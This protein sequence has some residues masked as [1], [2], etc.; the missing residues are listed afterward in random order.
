MY[1]NVRFPYS[2]FFIVLTYSVYM[3]GY[4]TWHIYVA[5]AFS[6]PVGWGVTVCFRCAAPV[7][8]VVPEF[9]THYF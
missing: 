8:P 3:Y 2:D 7:D 4:Y 6:Y 9:T 1:S 5:V